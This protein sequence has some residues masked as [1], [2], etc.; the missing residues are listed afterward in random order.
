MADHSNP[1]GIRY[2]IVAQAI[3]CS[4][5]LEYLLPYEV[6]AFEEQTVGNATSVEI[7]S[8]VKLI[9]I[10]VGE[11]LEGTECLLEAGVC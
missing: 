6:S 1:V 9:S 2:R 4:L 11:D 10:V 7:L 8:Q 5:H 3:K